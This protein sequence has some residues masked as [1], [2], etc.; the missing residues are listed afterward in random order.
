MGAPFLHKAVLTA[1]HDANKLERS[2]KSVF[3]ELGSFSGE[4]S[5]KGHAGARSV[6]IGICMDAGTLESKL[7]SRYTKKPEEAWNLAKWPRGFSDDTTVTNRL[8][9]ACDGRWVGY[10]QICPDMLYMPEDTKT[11]YVLL[12]DTRTW[13]PITTFKAKRFRGFTYAVPREIEGEWQPPG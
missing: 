7:E 4:K 11:P 12:F 2:V 3:K 1:G 10:F 13:T 5:E 9:V 8:F 6:D